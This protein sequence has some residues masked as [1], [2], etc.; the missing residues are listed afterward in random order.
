MDT[1]FCPIGVRIKGNIDTLF[2]SIGLLI[3]SVP[4]YSCAR[5]FSLLVIAGLGHKGAVEYR[6]RPPE[7]FSASQ[8]L[9]YPH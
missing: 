7:H 9:S 2:L 1:F 5:R 4:L 6:S 8:L 3:K